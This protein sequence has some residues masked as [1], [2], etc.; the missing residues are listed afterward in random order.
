MPKRVLEVLPK[1]FERYG[2]RLHPEKTRL[3]DFRR[4]SGGSRRPGRG[5]FTMLGFTHYWGTSLKGRRIVK[6]KTSVKSLSRALRSVWIWCRKHR[7]WS[8][9]DQHAALVRKVRGHYGYFGITGNARSLSNFVRQVERRWRYW[10]ARRGGRDRMPWERFSRLLKRY[11][12]PTPRIVHSFAR[13]AA[14]P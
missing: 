9:A 3:I 11:A 1:R 12:L 13:R 2:L 8:V 5:G 7:H 10:L 4:P 6:R 14:K